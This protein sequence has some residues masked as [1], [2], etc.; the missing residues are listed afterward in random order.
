METTFINVEGTG[1]DFIL[2]DTRQSSSDA[3]IALAKRL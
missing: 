1:N 3:V 2:M